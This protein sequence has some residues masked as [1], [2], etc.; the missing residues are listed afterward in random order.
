MDTKPLAIG[1]ILRNRY[2]VMR[3]IAGGGMAWV[4]QVQEQRSD[5][6]ASSGP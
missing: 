5:G 2:Q 1:T 3:L 4:Y 6:S